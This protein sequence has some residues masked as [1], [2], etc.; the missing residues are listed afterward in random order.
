[1]EIPSIS[2][3][4]RQFVGLLSSQDVF[5]PSMFLNPRRQVRAHDCS[6]L[7]QVEY[8]ISPLFIMANPTKSYAEAYC[9]PNGPG[10]ARPTALQVVEDNQLLGAWKGRVALV[11]GGTSG[12]G[13]ETV[14][15][16]YATGADVWFTARDSGKGQAVLEDISKNSL[17]E[18]LLQ[19]LAMNL[20]SLESVREAA[21]TFLKKSTKL[22]I[23]INNAGTKNFHPFKVFSC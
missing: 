11:T 2:K 14:R 12:I 7:T 23:L 17:G 18:G 20:D 4:F 16:L 8:I 13:V 5:K 19:V 1:M 22:H 6:L 10:D 21:D 15:A 3:K 9:S